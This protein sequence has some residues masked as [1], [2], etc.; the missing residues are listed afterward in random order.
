MKSQRLN[1]GPMGY[2]VSQ[3]KLICCLSL[4]SVFAFCTNGSAQP[5]DMAKFLNNQDANQNGKIEAREISNNLKESLKKSGFKI[6]D[7]LTIK[8]IVSGL[9]KT[10]KKSP[11]KKSS[12]TPSKRISKVPG[13]GTSSDDSDSVGVAKFGSSDSVSEPTEK[14]YSDSVIARVERSLERYDQDNN[15]FLDQSEI[16]RGR[17]GNPNVEESDTNKDGI[18]SR[19]ELS[20]RY[21]ARES[22]YRNSNWR[23]SHSKNGMRSS[24]TSS[25]VKDRVKEL[26]AQLSGLSSGGF[27]ISGSSG[28]SPKTESKVTSPKRTSPKPPASSPGKY[29]SYAKGLIGNYDEDKDGKLSKEEVKQMRSPPVGADSDKDGYITQ[30]ELIFNLREKGGASSAR[31]PRDV[32]SKTRTSGYSRRNPSSS[33]T[34]SNRSKSSSGFD[35]LDANQ[36]NRIHM[37]EYSDEWDDETVAEFYEKDKNGDGLITLEEWSNGK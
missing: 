30:T 22:Y 29:R 31:P 21:A 12:P 9:K 11:K 26:E 1:T 33:K 16:S 28:R 25:S 7:G 2:F 18:L 27:S 6:A 24:E 15:G 20:E 36:D 23:P 35:G 17:W 5:F 13:F 14:K 3:R 4:A 8:E 32:R 37:H 34:R 19:A 10:K